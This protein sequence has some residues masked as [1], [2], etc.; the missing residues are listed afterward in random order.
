VAGSR[1]SGKI[2]RVDEEKDNG[3]VRQ[4]NAKS[5]QLA[6]AFS[7]AVSGRMKIGEFEHVRDG[8]GA[9]I[10]RHAVPLF[11]SDILRGNNRAAI[12]DDDHP[13]VKDVVGRVIDQPNSKGLERLVVEFA[14]YI[15]VCHRQIS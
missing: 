2:R 11:V 1:A 7:L 12:A 15:V 14:D 5:G 4:R 3:I 8:N 13:G 10:G 9:P 6:L